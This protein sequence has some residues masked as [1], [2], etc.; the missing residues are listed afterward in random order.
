MKNEARAA[1]FVPHLGCPNDCVFCNQRV[2]AGVTLPAT[3]DDVHKAAALV[4]DSGAKNAELAFFGGSFTAIEREYMRELLSAAEK[5][6][7]VGGFSGIRLSTRPDC[8]SEDI[9]SELKAAGVTI[10]ELGAQS[11]RD[12][13]LAESGRGHLAQDTVRA[14]NMIKK[15]GIRLGLQ[16]MTGL[17]GD[18]DEGALYTADE[19]IKLAPECVRIYPTVVL[20]GTEL[21]AMYKR[22]EYSPQT[23]EKAVPLCVELCEKFEKAGITVIRLGLQRTESC[24]N[25]IVA[26]AWHPAFGELVYGERKYRF[27]R[28][29]FTENPPEKGVYAVSCKR[30]QVSV[31][32][33]QN[34]RNFKRISEQF[35]IMLKI[36]D[37]ERFEEGTV[38]RI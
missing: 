31:W 34:R 4:R 28:D 16:M 17:P 36:D 14:S 25:D 30:G 37:S 12:S 1:V 33:G 9:L 27:L 38:R 10:I 18:D 23:V 21:E 32:V 29:Y 35:G 11:M 15:S 6:L 8:I 26:G 7:S 22:G 5:E 13:V 19:I 20:K 3:A 2:I 24:E